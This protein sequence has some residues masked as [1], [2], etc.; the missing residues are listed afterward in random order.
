MNFFKKKLAIAENFHE[1]KFIKN[2]KIIPLEHEIGGEM[3]ENESSKFS[4]MF[5]KSEI[6]KILTKNQKFVLAC[7]LVLPINP[8]S[9]KYFSG[10]YQKRKESIKQETEKM[11]EIERKTTE[12]LLKGSKKFKILGS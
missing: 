7:F 10:E 4:Y 6:S 9:K 3:L 12:D 1:A 11:M 2:G 5:D 8:D